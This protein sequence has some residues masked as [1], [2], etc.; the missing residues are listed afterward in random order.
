MV[1][2]RALA[3]FSVLTLALAARGQAPAQQAGGRLPA[4]APS[5]RPAVG[6]ALEGGGALGIAHVGVLRWLEENRIPV[7]RLAGTSMGSLVGAL[8]AIGLSPEELRALAVSD[9]FTRVFT[10]QTP[11]AD[12]SFRRRQD[13]RELPQ[14]VTVGLRRFPGLRNAL[15]SDRGVLEFLSTNMAAWNR[16][17]ADY[18]RMPIPFRCVATDL[19]TLEPVTFAAG[20]LPDA[21]RASISIPGVFSPVQA[22]SGHFLVDGGILDNLPTDVLRGSLHADAVI[23]VHLDNG[24]VAAPDTS[25]IVTVLNRAFIAGV[26]LN[27]LQAQKLADLVISVPV[28]GF[29]GT[30]Y[31]RASELID[32]GYRAA[33]HNRAALQRFALDEAAWKAYLAARQSRRAGQPGTLREVRV[34]GGSPG[35]VREVERDTKPL[36][37]HPLLPATTL[38]ALKSVQSAG[39]LSA[40]WESFSAAAAPGAAPGSGTDSGLLVRL[41]GD[42]NGPPF[43]LIA[44][45]LGASTS[46][47]TREEM[48]LRLVHQ[49]LGGYGSELRADAHLGYRTDLSAGYYRMLTPGGWFVEPRARVVREP[50]YLWVNQKRV[51]ERFQQNLEVGLDTGRTFSRKFQVSGQWRAEET[52]WS[53]RAGTGGGP[54][55]SGT[56][57]TGVLHIVF[58]QA[59]AGLLSPSGFRLSLAAGALYHAAGSSNAPLVKASFSRTQPWRDN[60]FGFG[61]EI[62]SY[63]RANVAQPYRFTLGGPLSLSASSFDEY[64]GTDTALAHAGLMHR[65]ASLPTGVGQGLYVAIGYEAGEVWSPEARSFLRQDGITALVANTP[66]G[67]FTVG[68]SAGDA[69]HRKVY[70]TLG[71]WF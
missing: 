55:L 57:Q 25:S 68:A 53:L 65:I 31:A 8:Y 13:R 12:A 40:T 7:D 28:Q 30:D 34:E 3:L 43:L 16:D 70:V 33:E 69:G 51:A 44:P 49:N 19:N 56:A 5:G 22:R 35:A 24:D 47:I 37:G 1:V 41:H 60:I 59:Q 27:V 29:T 64:R 39:S 6:L 36:L 66:V 4:V 63:L 10:L 21:V 58:D 71:R 38:N 42:P 9:A 32:A 23:A 54:Y 52:Q 62:N 15:L 14:A 48:T 18:D 50:V 11:Y 20:P 17:D 2:K 45:E 46:N 26:Q 67:L 61:T